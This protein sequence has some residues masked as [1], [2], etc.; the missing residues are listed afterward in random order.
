VVKPLNFHRKTLK[1]EPL[2]DPAHSLRVTAVL[3]TPAEVPF[4]LVVENYAREM[5]TGDKP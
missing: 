5:A 3:L 1:M 4:S 2:G